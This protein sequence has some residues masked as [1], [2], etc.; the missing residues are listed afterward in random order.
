MIGARKAAADWL[1]ESPVAII[2]E[3][4]I[5]IFFNLKN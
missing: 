4:F 5:L 1:V 2:V 3:N